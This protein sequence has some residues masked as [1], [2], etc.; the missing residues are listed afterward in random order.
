[1]FFFISK[2]LS[3]LLTP[4]IWIVLLLVLAFLGKDEKRK[5]KLL[6]AAF[7]L[8]ILF[9]NSFL[10][11]ECMRRWEVPATSNENLQSSFNAG[12]ILSGMVAYDQSY[13]RLQFNRRNDRLMQAIE[14]YKSARIEKLFFTGGSGSIVHAD[15]KESLIVKRFLTEIGIPDSAIIIEAESN[16]THENAMFSKPILEKYFPKGKFLLITSAFH[17]R[18]ATSCFQKEGI[19]VTPYSTDRYSGPRKYQFDH[20]FIPNAE[21]LFNWDSLLHEVVGFWIYKIAGYA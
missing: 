17:M 10:F 11:D 12:I 9:S 21:T 15:K 1:M 7:V 14:L 16:N 4:V 8:L 2:I 18:R 19:A 6:R 5:K 20:L 3:F 13:D